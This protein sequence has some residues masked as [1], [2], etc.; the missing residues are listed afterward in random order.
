[1]GGKIAELDQPVY[2]KDGLTSEWKS[3]NVLSW[4]RGFVYISTDDERL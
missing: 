3:E 1:V 2:F 4:E